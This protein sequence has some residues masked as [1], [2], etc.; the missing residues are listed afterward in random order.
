MA[1]TRAKRALAPQPPAIPLTSLWHTVSQKQEGGIMR[2]QIRNTKTDRVFAKTDTR[3]AA[4]LI[5]SFLGLLAPDR[6]F[7]VEMLDELEEITA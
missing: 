2:F 6:R 1:R 5:L 4:D 7:I 3:E